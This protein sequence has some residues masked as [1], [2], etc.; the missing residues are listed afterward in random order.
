MPPFGHI[1]TCTTSLY[2]FQVCPPVPDEALVNRA[3][4]QLLM[5]KLGEAEGEEASPMLPPDSVASSS[6]VCSEDTT[7][8]S[9]ATHSRNTSTGSNTH[10]L[11]VEQPRQS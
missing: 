3:V 10:L 2:L 6:G 5:T 8:N 11:K 9:T 1:P 4:R 7:R